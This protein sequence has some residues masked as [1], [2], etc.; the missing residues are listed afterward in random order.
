LIAA[1]LLDDPRAMLG[2]LND[3]ME[4]ALANTTKAE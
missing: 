3:I 2:R 1:G 4:A